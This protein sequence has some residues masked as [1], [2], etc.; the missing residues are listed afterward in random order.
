M[1]CYTKAYTE[2]EDISNGAL[3]GQVLLGLPADPFSSQRAGD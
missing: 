1:T 2:N 3:L